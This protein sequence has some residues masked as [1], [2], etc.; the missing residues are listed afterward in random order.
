MGMTRVVFLPP[1]GGGGGGP[2]LCAASQR[3]I[4]S[5]TLLRRSPSRLRPPRRRLPAGH[6]RAPCHACVP[7]RLRRGKIFSKKRL[8]FVR[9]IFGAICLTFVGQIQ[10]ICLTFVRQPCLTFVRQIFDFFVPPASLG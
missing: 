1:S 6:R 3:Q 8:T 5:I 7:L 4:P 10:T 2:S 9:Q